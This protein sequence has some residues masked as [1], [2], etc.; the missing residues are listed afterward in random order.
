[1]T[2][3]RGEL[4]A[5]EG[6]SAARREFLGATGRAGLMALGVPAL[7][8]GN[9]AAALGATAASRSYA[10]GT[11][12]LALDGGFAGFLTGFVGGN[13]VA[14]VAK[15]APA[16]ADR[17]QR[18]RLGA[19]HVEPITVVTGLPM[20]KAFY[21]WIKS[22]IEPGSRP[23]ARNGAVVEYD[24]TFRELGRRTF[25]NAFITQVEF[26]SCDG[27]AKDQAGLVVTFSP[28]TVALTAGSAAAP[29]KPVPSRW[30]RSNFRL[31]IKG[32][33]QAL[34][35][36][37]AVDAL[38]IRIAP[39]AIDVQNLSITVDD[40]FIGQIYAWHQDFVIKGS[41]RTLPG[42]LEYLTPDLK[43]ALLTLNF[44]NLGI[45]RVAPE[46]LAPGATAQLRR[47][48]VEMY[49]EAVTVDFRG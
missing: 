11:Y 27:S 21:D 3:N 18:K 43:S 17:V 24:R 6:I 34:S 37:A 10:A 38:E 39:P 35:R 42:V 22:S 48:R 14:D 20:S 9:A 33:E 31:R 19:L 40:S 25:S 32:L 46:T 12:G 23:S 16:S 44:S 36:T 26:P 30:L 2:S 45:V 29:P 1:M 15:A 41:N 13:V 4:P 28:Q 7:A 8:L 47:S 49:C 5:T